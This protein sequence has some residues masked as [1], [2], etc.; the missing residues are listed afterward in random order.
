[1]AIACHGP[2]IGT[3]AGLWLLLAFQVGQGAVSPPVNAVLTF[4]HTL[5]SLALVFAIVPRVVEATDTARVREP[6]VPVPA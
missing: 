4:G 6:V 2:A 3:A 5:A 1:M